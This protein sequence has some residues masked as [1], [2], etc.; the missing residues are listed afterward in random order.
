MT[1]TV[2]DART[3]LDGWY[4][5]GRAESWDTVGLICGRPDAEVTRILV[6]VD[7][8]PAVVGEAIASEVDLV[9]THHP[10]FLRPVHGVAATTP[11]GR[12]VHDLVSHG[13]ALFNA[14][15]NADVAEGGVNDSFARAIGIVDPVPAV[16][17][18][19]ARSLDKITVFVPEPDANR[20]RGAMAS[21]G[22]GSLGSYDSCSF[23]TPGE[24]RFRPLPGADPVIGQVGDLE[25]V[26]EV[27]I[28]A[29][30]DR[31]L[32]AEVVVAMLAAHP[33]E[34]PAYDVVE[35]ANTDPGGPARG[36][37][38]MGSLAEPTTLAEY[39]RFVA[40][41]LPAT[42]HGVRVAGDPAREVRRVVA[43]SGAGDFMLDDVLG[44]DADVYVTSDLRHH[45]A[46]EFLE[47]RGPALIDVAHWAAEWTW[48]PVLA[49]RL[50][51]AFA[52]RGA[53]VDVL[54]SDTVTDAWTLHVDQRDR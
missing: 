45:P 2:G 47:H 6:S 50:T 5:P 15:T 1:I 8:A 52:E 29:V 25:V 21:A 31:G 40:S 27:R 34:T 16:P 22:A 49:D 18:S 33:Y 4:D 32:R 43:A 7:I 39:A 17:E 51:G 14:H 44:L 35:L 54:V 30:V 12:M 26:P 10:L 53:T 38:R 46:V 41:R 23:T 19:G 36:H 20:V 3:L 24:G 11:K 9:V 13:I 48:L 37:G 42:A 28:E